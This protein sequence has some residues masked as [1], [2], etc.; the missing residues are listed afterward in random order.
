MKNGYL[1]VA[2]MAEI[3]EISKQAVYDW[4]K[5]KRLKVYKISSTR[6][7]K[8]DD[9]LQYLRDRGNSP[10][11]MADFRKD[12]EDRLKRKQEVKK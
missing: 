5:D 4:I 3:F 8:P 10:G 2:D 11:V 9:L 1:T 7:I 6:R 12:I